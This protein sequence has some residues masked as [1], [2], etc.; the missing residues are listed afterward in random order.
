[1]RDTDV[2]NAK[3]YTEDSPEGYTKAVDEV[4]DVRDQ[5]LAKKRKIK[6]DSEVNM[7]KI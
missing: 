1:M 7:K 2:F 3:S 4:S 6:E 5:L